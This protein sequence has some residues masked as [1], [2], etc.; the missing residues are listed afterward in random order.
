MFMR[1]SM[2][3]LVS[4]TLVASGCS[5]LGGSMTPEQQFKSQLQDMSQSDY[6]VEYEVEMNVGGF[7]S[8]ISGMINEPE[9]YNRGD[10]SKFVVGVSSVTAA[11]YDIYSNDTVLCTQGSLFGGIMGGM[12]TGSS[13]GTGSEVTCQRAS[14]QYSMSQDKIDNWMENVTVSVEGTKT[15]A[16]RECR[17]YRVEESEDM[18]SSALPEQASEYA[19]NSTMNV[20][21]D[22]QKGYPA[23]ISVKQNQTSELRSDGM[24][25]IMRIEVTDY[26]T[27]FE[28]ASFDIPQDVS[29]SVECDPFETNVTT[30]DYSGE[31]TINVNEENNITRQVESNSKETFSLDNETMVSGSNEVTVYTDSGESA[32]ASCYDYSFDDYDFDYNYSN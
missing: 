15:I 6:H 20:C 2:I 31:V 11:A 5:M 9:I 17:N 13:T 3:L 28:G 32:S 29:S 23:L 18:N 14:D 21:L 26:D 7:G 12:G 24:K 1:L 10:Q 19:D 27:D 30:F 16:D 25:E 4:L 22:K 8:V